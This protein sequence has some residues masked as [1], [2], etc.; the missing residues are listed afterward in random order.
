MIIPFFEFPKNSHFVRLFLFFLQSLI[1]FVSTTPLITEPVLAR[2]LFTNQ[3]WFGL[4]LTPA[5]Y[6]AIPPP[7]AFANL[8]IEITHKSDSYFSGG[9]VFVVNTALSRSYRAWSDTSV[10]PYTGTP[11]SVTYY[12]ASN[13]V[14]AVKFAIQSLKRPDCGSPPK[15]APGTVLRSDALCCVLIFVCFVYAV[16]TNFHWSQLSGDVRNPRKDCDNPVLPA[17]RFASTFVR[18]IPIPGPTSSSQAF[19]MKVKTASLSSV[20]NIKTSLS[21]GKRYRKR[22]VGAVKNLEAQFLLFGGISSNFHGEQL[23]NDLW[24]LNA[25]SDRKSYAQRFDRL[26]INSSY[27]AL[28][29]LR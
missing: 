21:N 29:F 13:A 9:G 8:V 4:V 10:Y 6:I 18:T 7:S 5:Q 19:P 14:M 2:S 28:F 17:C 20:P 1:G 16:S 23:F 26:T 12:A 15:N 11:S 24:I 27:C 22:T 3:K 25:S